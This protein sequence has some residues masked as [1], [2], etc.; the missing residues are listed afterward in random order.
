MKLA[1]HRGRL[2]LVTDDG[3][4]DVDHASE[5]RFGPDPQAVYEDWKAFRAWAPT[6]TGPSAAY[7]AA[8]LG[9]PVPRPRPRRRCSLSIAPN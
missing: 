1:N 9:P 8:E 3:V 5:G 4:I 7:E 6:A 2:V